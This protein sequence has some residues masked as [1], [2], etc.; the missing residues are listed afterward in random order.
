[1]DFLGIIA[2]AAAVKGAA[3]AVKGLADSRRAKNQFEMMLQQQ[4]A[5]GGPEKAGE[6]AK[7]L[8]QT[9]ALRAGRRFLRIRDV[10]GNG[11][12]NLEESGLEKDVFNRIDINQDG[13]LS[14]AE[15][16]RGLV[17]GTTAAPRQ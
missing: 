10:D 7:E 15:V 14:L 3:G 17:N 2:A 11:R 5:A 16:Q 1:M 9:R 6:T 8:S 12:L 13:H 4:M